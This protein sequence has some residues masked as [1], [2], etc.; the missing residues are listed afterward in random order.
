[1]LYQNVLNILLS[2]LSGISL[3]FSKSDILFYLRLYIF[4]RKN[5]FVIF[6]EVDFILLIVRKKEHYKIRAV[7]QL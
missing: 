4:Y 7:L 2:L 3:L 1:M 6:T 5:M